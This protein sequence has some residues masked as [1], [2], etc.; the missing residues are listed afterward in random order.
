[1]ALV[2]WNPLEFVDVVHG[3]WRLGATIVPLNA[4]L[5]IAEVAWQL[6]DVQ[7]RL[8]LHD[9]RTATVASAAAAE[10]GCATLAL[11]HDSTSGTFEG[12]SSHGADDVACIMFTSGTTGSP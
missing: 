4:R 6:T 1:V 7:A 11:P 8:L 3:C 9:A 2:A 12:V 10:A 5:S